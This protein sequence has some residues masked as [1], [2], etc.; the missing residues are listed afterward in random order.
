MTASLRLWV[1]SILLVRGY[2]PRKRVHYKDTAMN[3]FGLLGIGWISGTGRNEYD[4]HTLREVCNVSN[5]NCATCSQRRTGS[6]NIKSQHVEHPP[7]CNS[8]LDKSNEHG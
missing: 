6:V 1:G 5:L 7:C 2:R 4:T 8:M 3:R